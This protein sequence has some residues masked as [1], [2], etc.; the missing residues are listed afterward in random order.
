MESNC[1]L[2]IL[3]TSPATYTLCSTHGQASHNQ[4]RS[5]VEAVVV[6]AAVALVVV[7]AAKLEEVAE[8]AAVGVTVE[9]SRAA[10]AA[11]EIMGATVGA[12]TRGSRHT[13][14]STSTS[15]TIRFG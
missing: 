5:L 2:H 15:W 11:K 10:V 9:A 12:D 3:R 4:L 1:I 7:A 14:P 8:S 6:E 13:P